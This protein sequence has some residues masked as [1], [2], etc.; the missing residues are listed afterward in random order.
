[1]AQSNPYTI[2]MQQFAKDLEPGNRNPGSRLMQL[3]DG[4]SENPSVYNDEAPPNPSSQYEINLDLV[5]RL[6]SVRQAV[7]GEGEDECGTQEGVP[8]I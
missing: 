5:K 6:P 3:K 7:A 4:N 1:M 2:D 8:S